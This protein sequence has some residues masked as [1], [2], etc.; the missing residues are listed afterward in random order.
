MP[1]NFVIVDSGLVALG[2]FREA[3]DQHRYYLPKAL[4]PHPDVCDWWLT[5]RAQCMG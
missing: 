5:C 2:L 1:P 4:K 3:S